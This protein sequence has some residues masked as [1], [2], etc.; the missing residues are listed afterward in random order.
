MPSVARDLLFAET[1]SLLR[2][3]PL[4][5]LPAHPDAPKPLG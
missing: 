3:N 4:V 2:E 5:K 1:T